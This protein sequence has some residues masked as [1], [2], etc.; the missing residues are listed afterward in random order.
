MKYHCGRKNYEYIFTL[1]R[2]TL[3]LLG[4]CL[5]CLLLEIEMQRESANILCHY[6]IYVFL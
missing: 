5:A 1:A 2:H 3:I 4:L 6:R